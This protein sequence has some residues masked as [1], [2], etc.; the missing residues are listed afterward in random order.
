MARAFY[1]SGMAFLFFALVLSFLSSI[2]LPYLPALDFA[3]VKF[4]SG[5]FSGSAETLSQVRV[6]ILAFSV[7][8]RCHLV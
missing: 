3:R 1:L 2:S 5:F 4:K 7:L 8:L 6:C